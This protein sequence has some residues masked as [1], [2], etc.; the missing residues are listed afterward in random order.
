[1]A[2][3]DLLI[4]T[5]LVLISCGLIGGIMYVLLIP[6]TEEANFYQDGVIVE[7]MHF[8]FQ[9]IHLLCHRLIY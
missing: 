6:R 8:V 1:M 5:V 2:K 9:K 3:K 4:G 7:G